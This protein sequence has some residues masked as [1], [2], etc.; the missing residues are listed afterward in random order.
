VKAKGRSWSLMLGS[1]EQCFACGHE[2]A[3]G[4]RCVSFCFAPDYLEQLAADAGFVKGLPFSIPRIPPLRGTA[5]MVAA[6]AANVP[7]AARAP[8]NEIGVAVAGRVVAL[9]RGVTARYRT[10]L[11]AEARVTRIVRSLDASAHVPR[12]STTWLGLPVSA[13]SISSGPS[14][15]LRA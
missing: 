4:D 3:E 1:P 14:H 9:A 6:A 8:W 12:R 7:D 10:P 5:P 15:V 2:H 13:P 11:N